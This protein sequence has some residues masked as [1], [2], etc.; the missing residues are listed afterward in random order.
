MNADVCVVGAGPAGL[1]LALL[2]A[3]SGVR[4]AV[5]ERSTSLGRE[6]RGEI[7]QPGGQRLLDS[8]GVLEPARERGAHEH[9]RFT[10]LDRGRVLLDSDYRS[11]PG[12]Y[13]CLLSIPQPHV[14][15][16]LL[17]ECRRYPGFEF[18]DGCR[19]TDLVIDDGVVRGVLATGRD[20]ARH[21]V[22]AHCV[23]GADGRYSKVR[24]L[25][26]MADGRRELFRQDVL[27]FKL[28]TQE[29][30][31]DAVRVFRETASHPVLAY[32]AVPGRIQFGWTL[33]HNGYANIA[34]LGLDHIKSELCR[35]IPSYADLITE[36][37]TSPRDL[38]LL[39]VF[40]ALAPEWT[41]DGL[42]LIGDSAHAHSPIGAQG[43]NLAIA[44]AVALHPVLLASLRERDA[45]TE[46]LRSRYEDRRRPDIV[47]TI[48]I[49]VM[50][51][52]MMLSHH[53]IARRL[54]PVA[55]ALVARSPL[56]RRVRDTLAFGNPDLQITD[57]PARE[58]EPR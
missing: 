1:T 2:L 31:P 27:W 32:G 41:R 19:V 24:K 13:N 56:Y 42:V 58:G 40:A 30:L 10:L 52:R 53:P 16:A 33:P 4:V 47:R 43:I 48:R 21:T 34:A 7:L 46:F 49:Q 3:R 26:T 29:Q 9:G 45:S 25:A 14:L 28:P 6:F 37:I 22:H 38:T 36:R 50:Q 55:A 51:S 39:D 17:T 23:V 11:L 15:D 54:R 8:L 35:A 18:L 57:E 44:D 20:G 12:P 5:V